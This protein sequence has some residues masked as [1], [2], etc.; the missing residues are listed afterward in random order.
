MSQSPPVKIS[1]VTLGCA[2]N[3][4]DSEHILGRLMDAGAI[5]CSNSSEADVIIVNTC[6]FILPAKE[7]SIDHILE[8]AQLKKAD[9]AKKLIV[10]GC[11]AERYGSQLRKELPE[12]DEVIGLRRFEAIEAACGI[13]SRESDEDVPL[14]MPLTPRHI[15]FLRIADGCNNR[16]AYCAIPDI[17]GP[18]RSVSLET[19]MSGAEALAGQ[20]AREINVIAQDVTMYGSDLS[21]RRT[22]GE[23]I[24]RVSEIEDIRWIRLLYAHPAH[25]DDDAIVAM[26]QS[27]K[28]CHYVDLP[29]Q[30]LDDHVLQRMRRK[31]SRKDIDELVAKLRDAMPDIAIRTTILVGFPGEK[32]SHFENLLEGI[33][34]LQ[35]DWLGAFTYSPEQGTP[36]AS[37]RGHVPEEI[38]QERLHRLMELQQRIHIEKSRDW[39]GRELEVVVDGPSEKES[40]TWEARSYA[41][42][43]EVDGTIYLKG[44]GLEQGQFLR[45]RITGAEGY[46]LIGEAD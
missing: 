7:E 28:V 12:I 38:K 2:K 15:A 37:F 34:R 26:A 29:I 21:P 19:I 5:L 30:H 24:R 4:V 17:R 10:T 8:A 20:G 46:D 44:A 40:G 42:A 32:D 9:P 33:E 23:L 41:H 3:L 36:A 39:I 25:L 16:C 13:R 43:Y 31:V 6:G 14:R 45:A 22:L 18:F 1:L 35:F 11:L 27:E